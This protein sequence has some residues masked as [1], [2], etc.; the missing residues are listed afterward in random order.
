MEGFDTAELVPSANSME[1][2]F[3]TMNNDGSAPL[4]SAPL[5]KHSAAAVSQPR[6]DTRNLHG[7]KRDRHFK[8]IIVGES[9]L[10]KTTATECLVHDLRVSESSAPPYSEGSTPPKTLQIT[11]R[12]KIQL[13]STTD[14]TDSEGDKIWLRIVDTPGYGDNLDVTE[15][16]RRIKRYITEQYESLYKAKSRA[17]L[18]HDSLVTCCLYFIAPHRIKDNDIEFLSEVSKMVP[19]IPVIAKADTM[20]FQETADFRKEV[21][22]KLEEKNIQ[23]YDWILPDGQKDPQI[24]GDLPP[25]TIITDKS[26][27]KRE[28]AW[29]TCELEN[30]QHS[31]FMLLKDLV[32]K[33]H[34][35]LMHSKAYDRYEDEYARDAGAG[36]D[37]WT[38]Y[39]NGR[40]LLIH[41]GIT[42]EQCIFVYLLAITFAQFLAMAWNDTHVDGLLMMTLL[43]GEVFTTFVVVAHT[44][45]SHGV[46][47]RDCKLCIWRSLILLVIFLLGWSTS[48]L[49]S[50]MPASS[51]LSA[52]RVKHTQELTA[53]QSECDQLELQKNLIYAKSTDQDKQVRQSI[54]NLQQQATNHEQAMNMALKGSQGSCAALNQQI[55]E[56][57]NDDIRT[58]TEARLRLEA[59][60]E[61]GH[62]HT[63]NQETIRK[64]L[65]IELQSAQNAL[66]LRTTQLQSAKE[67]NQKCWC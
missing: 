40:D 31:D 48:N 11:E 1:M 16:F 61:K 18:D 10:G 58:A 44:L 25:F 5:A 57:R 51:A 35:N 34:L 12:D 14:G 21:V 46:F 55:Q 43:L 67:S 24:K 45:Y 32:I 2:Q 56:A 19:V 53:L 22:K 8:I 41:T 37:R 60:V 30:R 28:Y 23:T 66:K 39:Y 47:R 38:W 20:T 52:A 6:V 15:D 64:T 65:E 62:A 59:D 49:R 26:M 36:T 50:S 13:R 9:G 42:W 33:E 3:P 63:I 54:E 7:N 4:P 29:G 27:A 17:P